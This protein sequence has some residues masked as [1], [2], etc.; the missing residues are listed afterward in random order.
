MQLYLYH[1]YEI[2]LSLVCVVLAALLFLVP[3]IQ[4]NKEYKKR[5]NVC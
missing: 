2:Y 4:F 1:L 5:N 3:G